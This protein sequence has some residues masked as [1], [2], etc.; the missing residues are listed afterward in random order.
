[1]AGTQLPAFDKLSRRDLLIGILARHYETA[2]LKGG[3]FGDFN[4]TNDPDGRDGASWI[5]H[6]H[7][8]LEHCARQEFQSIIKYNQ[9]QEEYYREAKLQASQELEAR[10]SELSLNRQT[11]L[12]KNTARVIG[13]KT[14][15]APG[16]GTP[17]TSSQIEPTRAAANNVEKNPTKN[18][19]YHEHDALGIIEDTAVGT[20]RDSNDGSAA[21]NNATQRAL[22]FSEEILQDI[23]VARSAV[24]VAEGDLSHESSK[25]MK[26]NVGQE[27]PS[28]A[29][30]DE[31]HYD[32]SKQTPPSKKHLISH[33]DTLS[34]EPT[35][36]QR[37]LEDA[38]A[39]HNPH[40]CQISG[41]S[42][43][44]VLKRDRQMFIELLI[45]PELAY[46]FTHG[47]LEIYDSDFRFE[48]G[49]DF[50][51]SE[52][53]ADHSAV[54]VIFSN[55]RDGKANLEKC[56]RFVVKEVFSDKIEKSYC[57]E[58]LA[59]IR[60][61][62]NYAGE[63]SSDEIDL[64][65]GADGSKCYHISSYTVK[66]GSD[67]ESGE[68]TDSEDEEEQDAEEKDDEERD[69]KSVDEESAE[70]VDISESLKSPDAHATLE[71]ESQRDGSDDTS[72]DDAASDSSSGSEDYDLDA[73]VAELTDKILQGLEAKGL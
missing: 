53:T 29:L 71:S 56:F 63:K 67:E 8:V 41:G 3:R 48:D 28:E 40:P 68:A 37:R 65:E 5:E 66:T 10:L 21:R 44:D 73:E 54:Y 47:Y 70:G 42:L 46:R 58:I 2:G 19:R 32:L 64:N 6:N 14:T 33:D 22:E 11:L 45:D 16:A 23:S 39:E 20:G 59:P 61:V 43:R 13:D 72:A 57:K 7:D 26:V 24:Q 31:K 15:E 50:D 36:K 51:F 27:E 60:H 30:S 62:G 35:P 4:A 55:T 25:E 12:N 38:A 9:D 49:A 17:A 1:M 52:I 34:A 69:E 18:Q